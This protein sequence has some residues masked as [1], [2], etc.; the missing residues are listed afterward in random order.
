MISVRI[1]GRSDK[2]PDF[3]AGGALQRGLFV[4]YCYIVRVLDGFLEK[5]FGFSKSAG[6]QM[7]QSPCVA[8]QFGIR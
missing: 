3:C 2:G 6:L 5:T 7:R 1:F 8:G 4:V